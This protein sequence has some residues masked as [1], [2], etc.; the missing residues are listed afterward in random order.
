MNAAN[1]II[2]STYQEIAGINLTVWAVRV[3]Q[4]L[5]AQCQIYVVNVD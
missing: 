4:V 5:Q 3:L 2:S 1:F